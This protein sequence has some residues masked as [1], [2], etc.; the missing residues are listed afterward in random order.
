M[1]GYWVLMFNHE[2]NPNQSIDM[3]YFKF[4]LILVAM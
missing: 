2:F 1:L 4:R 3:T